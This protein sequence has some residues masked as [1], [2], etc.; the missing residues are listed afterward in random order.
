MQ[1]EGSSWCTV[2]KAKAKLSC[3]SNRRKAS[4]SRT[5][6]ARG[7]V[8]ESQCLVVARSPVR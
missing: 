8:V 3:L 5:W 7:G 6:R 1:A 4:V 2:P